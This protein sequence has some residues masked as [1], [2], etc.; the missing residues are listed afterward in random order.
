LGTIHRDRKRRLKNRVLSEKVGDPLVRERGFLN[1]VENLVR[2]E[3]YRQRNKGRGAKA[4]TRITLRTTGLRIR[5][6]NSQVH[7]IIVWQIDRNIEKGGTYINWTGK[8]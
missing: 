7:A 6:R 1:F 3:G 8:K 4:S 2:G 5:K